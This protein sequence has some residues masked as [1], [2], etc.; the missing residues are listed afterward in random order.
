MNYISLKAFFWRHSPSAL[1]SLNPEYGTSAFSIQLALAVLIALGILP[2]KG[3]KKLLAGAP[4]FLIS[5]LYQWCIGAQSFA[6]RV[7][8][9]QPFLL[10]TA[11]LTCSHHTV[12]V[13]VCVCLR[14][15][16]SFP[17][18]RSAENGQGPHFLSLRRLQTRFRGRRATSSIMLWI[19]W[20]YQ[21]MFL[22]IMWS[23]DSW[24]RSSWVEGLG[25]GPLRSIKI[26]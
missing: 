13:S 14:M 5:S 23:R 25:V 17:W 10:W 11:A 12:C 16:R 19:A 7:L 18:E 9:G 4:G 21:P 22:D 3:G 26:C 20:N 2:W 15:E 8:T 6:E 1:T 24:K